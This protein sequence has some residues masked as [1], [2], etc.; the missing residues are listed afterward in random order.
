LKPGLLLKLARFLVPDACFS[1]DS[2]EIL[3]P[4]FL[5]WPQILG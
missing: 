4:G 3:K 2:E 5:N 1:A